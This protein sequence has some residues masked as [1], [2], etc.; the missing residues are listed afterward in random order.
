VNNSGLVTGVA[1]GNASITY[2]VTNGNGCVNVVN[3]EVT[4]NSLPATP[5]NLTATPATIFITFL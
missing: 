4:V 1:F 3:T 5:S 2:T